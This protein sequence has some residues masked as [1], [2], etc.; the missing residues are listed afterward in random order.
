MK[1]KKLD[2]RNLDV[3]SDDVQ[4][5]FK[6]IGKQLL[7]LNNLLEEEYYMD[8]AILIKEK[9]RRTKATLQELKEEIEAEIEFKQKEIDSEIRKEAAN[10]RA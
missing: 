7:F 2:F 6:R 5:V 4:I 1:D 10:V 3:L 9:I 8:D